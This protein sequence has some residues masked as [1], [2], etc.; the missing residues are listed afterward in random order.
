MKKFE[1]TKKE[2]I[3]D[4]HKLYQ[5]KAL[6]NFGNVK[7]GDLGGFVEKEENLSQDDNCWIYDNAKVYDNACVFGDAKVCNYAEISE[8]ATIK[9][10]VLV[11]DKAKVSGVAKVLDFAAVL[12]N[13]KISDNAIVSGFSEVKENAKVLGNARVLGLISIYGDVE[14]SGDT[15]IEGNH[16]FIDT[17]EKL[18]EFISEHKLD[19]NLYEF[20]T[21]ND[22][23]P[24]LENENLQNNDKITHPSIDEEEM[25]L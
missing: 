16:D 20:I 5:I 17:K 23:K 2:I 10:P 24:D 3:Y 18:Q 8:F 11:C 6:K 19:K 1:L 22:E 25:E 14:V 4:D 15:C 13:A 9:G 12:G 21:N 7:A